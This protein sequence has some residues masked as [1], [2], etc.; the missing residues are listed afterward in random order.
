MTAATNAI[1][2][3]KIAQDGGVNSFSWRVPAITPKP[4]KSTMWTT[5][6]MT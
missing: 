1:S 2:S 3:A 6:A 4:S 5:N